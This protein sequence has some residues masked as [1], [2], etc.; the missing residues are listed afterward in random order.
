MVLF[1]HHK[2]ENERAQLDLYQIVLRQ[3]E[4]A[5]LKS[6]GHSSVSQSRIWC[7]KAIQFNIIIL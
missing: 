7:L 3:N 5:L 2:E 6:G 4:A 1:L